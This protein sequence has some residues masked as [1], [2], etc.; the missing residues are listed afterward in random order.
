MLIVFL[1]LIE[2]ESAVVLHDSELRVPF[3]VSISEVYL[4]PSYRDVGPFSVVRGG[5]K[6]SYSIRQVKGK[7]VVVPFDVDPAVRAHTL[8]DQHVSANSHLKPQATS[9][10]SMCGEQM[11]EA[12]SVQHYLAD[13]LVQPK[14]RE[15]QCGSGHKFCFSCWS[16]FLRAHASGQDG[17]HGLQCPGVNCGENLDLQW[18]P[19]LL[20]SPDL[21]NRVMTQ[22]LQLVAEKLRLQWCTVPNCGLIVHVHAAEGEEVRGSDCKAGNIPLCGLCANGHGVCVCCGNEPHAPCQCAELAQWHE[23]VREVSR[24]SQSKDQSGAG[25][26]L[27]HAPTHKD[28]R[29]C[30]ASNGKE[31]GSNHIRCSACHRD[32]CWVCL[33]DWELHLVEASAETEPNGHTSFQCNNFMELHAPLPHGLSERHAVFLQYFAR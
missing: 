29:Q 10:C 14:H 16:G 8:D 31:D 23:L 18:A 26:M 30:G 19:V 3:G 1:L 4:D 22:R 25:H 32:F 27:L 21:V 33:Q 13:T 7:T 28:C 6:A 24:T 17:L 12:C 2:A 11:M 9:V 20:N 15:L 5:K